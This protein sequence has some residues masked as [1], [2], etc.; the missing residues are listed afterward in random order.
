MK[1]K[2]V[3]LS[4]I[5]VFLQISLAA[6]SLSY[7]GT[8]SFNITSPT[9]IDEHPIPS[10]ER[11]PTGMTFGDSGNKFYIVG[12][13]G[14]QV[15][16]YILS[17]AYD[18]ST[19]GLVQT[20]FRVNI[21]ENAPDD[22]AFND[23][24]TK[25][26]IVGGDGDD[27]TEYSLS[28]AW[29]VST[30]TFTD[31]FAAKVQ[32]EAYLDPTSVVV[33][34]FG[35]QLTGMAFNNDGS[36]LYI[37]D[38]RSDDVFEFDL[39]TNYDVSTA[40][41]VINNH[42][43]AGENNVRSIAF[44]NDGTELYIL[45]N[46]GD[47]INIVP[48]SVA[49]DLS[50]AGTPSTASLP[51][52]GATPRALLI[53]NNG[54]TF[55]IAGSADDN[56]KEYTLDTG[57]DFSTTR[58]FVTTYTFP[59]IETAPQGMV[60]NNDGTKLFVTGTQLDAVSELSLSIPYDI[61]TATYIA[62]LYVSAEDGSPR[63]LA[64]NNTGTTLYIIGSA[65]D[66]INGY[67][68]STA[69]DLTSTITTTTSSPFDI[70]IEENNP[71][72][73]F[74]NTDGTKLFVLGNT[75]NDLNQYS[76]SPAYDL[77][78]AIAANLDIAFPL[79]NVSGLVIDSAPLGMAFN[80]D[81]SKLFIAGNS[82][83]DI[84]EISL[85]N[86]FDLSTGT[87]T[88]TN[89]FD[90]SS[91][92][93]TIT[94]VIFNGDGSKFFIC[95]TIGDDM[96]QYFTHGNYDEISTTNNGTLDNPT[97]LVFTITGDTFAGS[98]GFLEITTDFTITNLPEG[99]TPI[100][101][102]T[103]GDTAATL[104]FTG[105]AASHLNSNDI[106]NLIFT[107]TDDAFTSSTAV[108]LG[109][110]NLDIMEIDFIDCISDIVYDGTW[111]GGSGAGGAP[112][113]SD[114]TKGIRIQSDV[115][116]ALTVDCFCVHVETG[117]TLS[118]ADAINLNISGSLELIGDL[119]LLGTSQLKQTHSGVKNTSGTGNL[120]KDV[121]GTLSNVYQTGYWTS[122]VTTNGSNY[123]IAGVLK[124]GTTAL[125][126]SN[127]PLD[128][129]FSSD[130][131]GDDS[132]SPVTL[133][134]RWLAKFKNSGAWTTFID[135]TTELFNPGEG[136]SK[137]ST[138][139]ASGQNYTFVGRPNDGD[140]TH[141]IDAFGSGTWSLLGNPYPSPIDID[142]FT[143]ENSTAIEGTIYF[144][145]AG[146]DIDHGQSSY[147]GGYASRVAGV[148]NSAASLLDGT[149]IK[150]PGQYL[151]VGQGFFV[152]A[153]ATGGTITFNN[154]TQRAFNTPNVFFSKNKS[155]KT[156]SAF[157]ILRV[158]FEFLY[159][160]EMYH[161]PV[162]VAFRGL[163]NALEKGFEAEMWD[164]K[165]TD[166]ALKIDGTNSPFAISG[167]EDFNSSL[168]IPLKVQSDSNREV[169]FKV[170]E[171]IGIDN[172]IV[173]LYDN[174]TQKHHNITTENAIIN[175]DS[176]IYDDR[177]FITFKETILGL[178]N[179]DVNKLTII[180]TNKKLIISSDNLLDE[181]MIYNLLGQNIIALNNSSKL[182]EVKVNITNFKKGIYI[183][184]AKNSKGIFTQKIIIK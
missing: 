52:I 31:V 113:T 134:T 13:I 44:N 59:S 109:A 105:V 175:L 49:Y 56:I 167:T 17:T 88:I 24:G 124:D 92:E 160:G 118:V 11:T 148:G 132:T 114:T 99:I 157:P 147:L 14:D 141:T 117:N 73:I 71:S 127:T 69:Y 50:S 76:L 165:S 55:Y 183:V 116:L 107:F 131:D 184:K 172:S 177:F 75:G 64:F 5:F 29:D 27:I 78:D 8:N 155:K 86:N 41:A 21:E 63:G 26:Y 2:Y 146:N 126:V 82:G 25:M 16:Q 57:F 81:G 84:N 79:N 68:I 140:Y 90:I 39:S 137:K 58:T 96:N 136:F 101:T 34:D 43:I 149:G 104:T 130:L 18:V 122:P 162:S 37:A 80:S 12:A 91:E 161:R 123:N 164:Y 93:G 138:G 142:V 95:G 45:G 51:S 129:T 170:D 145:E 150:V 97:P 108:S 6:Q 133:S 30:A 135:K 163:T 176:G 171:M 125:T 65:G 143:T 9:H 19:R 120:Y 66:E 180:N 72:D 151:G 23:D 85:S 153:S 54:E 156:T 33:Q 62:S 4:W 60:F 87:Q 48:L 10:L 119:R 47:D 40:G 115:T 98:G 158:G 179:N 178:N 3:F 168:V 42:P 77:T 35:D 166:M 15:I 53:N 152:V 110:T 106:A 121:T 102:L 36:K 61:S 100:L 128:I 22:V 7:S 74:F 111:S 83:N 1:L 94:D 67:D 112:N 89:T 159:N 173:Y 28:T 70:S 182:A 174:I 20:H 32:I 103:A 169:T 139:N 144:Y 181:I 38:R 46:Q 154:N